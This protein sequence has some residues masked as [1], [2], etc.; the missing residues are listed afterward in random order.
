MHI[1]INY[2]ISPFCPWNLGHPAHTGY[3][4]RGRATKVSR[5]GRKRFNTSHCIFIVNTIVILLGRGGSYV[6]STYC[7]M[8]LF[9]FP[10]NELVKM[11]NYLNRTKSI[12]NI[13]NH[14]KVHSI[15]KNINSAFIKQ[16]KM[17]G[18]QANVRD[19]FF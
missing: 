8:Y 19:F 14:T 6:Q 2:K 16:I 5:K 18:K 10:P 11:G 4:C 13:I 1:L 7:H 17:K 12:G 9:V 15:M 3:L